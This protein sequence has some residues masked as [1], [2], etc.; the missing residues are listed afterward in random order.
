LSYQIAFSLKHFVFG[1]HHAMRHVQPSTFIS[2]FRPFFEPFVI[3]SK[4]FRGP[5]AVTMPLHIFDFILWGSS[6]QDTQYHQFTTDYVPYNSVEFREYYFMARNS[7]SIIDRCEGEWATTGISVSGLSIL[8]QL[9]I[10]MK[11]VRAFRNAHLKYAILA[12]HGTTPHTFSSGSGGHTTADLDWLS[13]LTEKHF[14][15]LDRL[16]SNCKMKTLA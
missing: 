4:S 11:R 8:N 9:I 3:G 1:L 2:E 5:G 13:S 6:E 14:V 12:Y 15:R 10:S 7:P 16:R